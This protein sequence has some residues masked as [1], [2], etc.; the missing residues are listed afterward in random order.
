[1]EYYLSKKIIVIAKDQYVVKGTLSQVTPGEIYISDYKMT[2]LANLEEPIAKGS[3]EDIL[4]I[5]KFSVISMT[6]Q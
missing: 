1:M 5:P 4:I 6:S 2:T 3:D